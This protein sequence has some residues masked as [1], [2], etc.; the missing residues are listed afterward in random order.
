[1]TIQRRIDLPRIVTGY[2]AMILSSYF[3]Y[4]GRDV[5]VFLASG[6]FLLICATDTHLAQI[7]NAANLVMAVAGLVYQVVTGGM[8]GLETSL[9][10]MA[11]LPV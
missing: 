3:I 8:T 1:M 4:A 6:F 5:P 9:L 2:A 10:G 7:P 11:A